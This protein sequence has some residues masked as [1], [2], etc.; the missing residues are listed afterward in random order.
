MYSTLLGARQ[1]AGCL[2]Y[3]HKVE[4]P[5]SPVLKKF[6]GIIARRKRVKSLILSTKKRGIEQKRTFLRFGL[7]NVVFDIL[8]GFIHFILLSYF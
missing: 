6:P 8:S 3:K 1:R 5:S 2:G 7:S 4:N